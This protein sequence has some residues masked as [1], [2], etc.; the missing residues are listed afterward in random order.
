MISSAKIANDSARKIGRRR[1]CVVAMVLRSMRSRF[2]NIATI[3]MIRY[4]R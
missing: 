2:I 3:A 4:I 1:F